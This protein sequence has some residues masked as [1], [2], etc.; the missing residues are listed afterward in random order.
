MKIQEQ[1][2]L[3][4]YTWFRTGGPARYFCE[5]VT[6]SEV[7]QALEFASDRSIPVFMLGEGANILVSDDG[8]P[9]L[10]IRQ[11]NTGAEILAREGE[12]T[13]VRAGSGVVI[14]DLIEYCL[15]GQVTGLEVFSGIPGTVGGAVYI[16]LHYFDALLSE[17]FQR[18]RVITA[19]GTEILDVDPHWFQFGYDTSTLHSGEHY[20]LEAIFQLHSADA[21]ETAFA[22]GRREEIIR[23]RDRRYPE[24]HTCGSFFRNFHP[25]EVTLKIDGEDMIYVAYYLDQ[26][27]VKG[28][29][30]QGGAGVSKKHANMIVNSGE[31]SSSDIIAVARQMQELVREEFGVLPKPECQLIGFDEYPLYT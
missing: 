21:E 28:R 22:R 14:S 24:S 15:D 11:R 3:A 23:H 5:P 31:G 25:E 30:Q 9:G 16:N 27:G 8:F 10:V 20:L 1:I 12:K 26:L 17:F 6:E 7:Q 2:P 29:L 19:D 18:G 4:P 13:L